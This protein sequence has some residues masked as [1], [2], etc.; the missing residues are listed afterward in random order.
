MVINK[1]CL[2]FEAYP[3]FSGA[4][5][6]TLNLCKVL[7]KNGYNITL[8]LADD[9]FGL[10]EKNF[11]GIVDEIIFIKTSEVLTKYGDE[12][13]WFS[14]KTFLKS[15][16]KG[17]IP[18]YIQSLKIIKS[19]KYD[20]LYCCDPRGAVMMLVAATMFKN[21][22]ILHFH[23]K[24]RVP[25]VLAKSFMSTFD[26]IIC[27][28]QDV[29]D[30]LP[31]SKKKSTI[32]NG[33]D[34]SQYKNIDVEQVESQI[35]GK[36]GNER[37]IV[38]FLYVGAIRP[39]KGLH[40]IIHAF[41]TINDELAAT[42]TKAVLFI[43]GEAKSNEEI[44]FKKLLQQY[45]FD[46]QV[47]DKIFWIGWN[48][49]VLGWMKCSNYL[50]FASV[51][52]EKNTYEGF[53]DMI[54]SSEGLPTVLVESSICGLYSIASDVTGVKEVVTPGSNGYIYDSTEAGLIGGIKYVLNNHSKFISFPKGAN[55]TVAFF[56]KK[57][58]EI[59]S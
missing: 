19:S 11:N 34:F 14:K 29:A 36:T 40:H 26:N 41:K 39:H 8:L 46:N 21:K 47:N 56:E 1:R 48:N 3:F 43:S 59:F 27:V 17:L 31:I 15:I 38:R 33:I 54:E 42:S 2:I 12:D 24:S 5:R 35:T 55:F 9:R 7:K 52:P 37:D 13:S 57:M 32:Y 4:Q 20:F 53:G 18:F 51:K 10:I 30:S 49:D 28:S 45:A 22:K 50:L 58:L 6:I 25:G 16:F 44:A 23:G